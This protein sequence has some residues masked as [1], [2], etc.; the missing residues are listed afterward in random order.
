MI[1]NNNASITVEVSP[2]K[3]SI[4]KRILHQDGVIALRAGG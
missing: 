2:A 1:R 3:S 4:L